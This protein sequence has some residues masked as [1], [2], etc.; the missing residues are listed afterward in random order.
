MT[1]I[2]DSPRLNVVEA[3]LREKAENPNVPDDMYLLEQVG[4]EN[5]TIWQNSKGEIFEVPYKGVPKK[6]YE[7]LIEY[8]DLF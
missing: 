3:T 8:I 1:G 7:S 2:C 5:L 4:I 6:I